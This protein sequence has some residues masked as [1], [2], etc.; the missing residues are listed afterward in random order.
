MIPLSVAEVAQMGSA[1]MEHRGEVSRN[2]YHMTLPAW[3]MDCKR[4][5]S[6]RVVGLGSKNEASIVFAQLYRYLKL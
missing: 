4:R 5:G 6:E 3:L 2:P 1:L